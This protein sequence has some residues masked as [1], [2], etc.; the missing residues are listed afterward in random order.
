[1]NH[2]SVSPDQ[3]LHAVVFSGVDTRIFL[4]QSGRPPAPLL[5]RRRGTPKQGAMVA[6]SRWRA[7]VA[8]VM[9]AIRSVR[10]WRSQCA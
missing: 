9:N 2:S 5:L 3:A 6:P 7:V 8:M 4:Q 1:M 10:I